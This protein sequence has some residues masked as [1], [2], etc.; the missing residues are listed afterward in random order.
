MN[1]VEHTA[2]RRVGEQSTFGRRFVARLVNAPLRLAIGLACV[3]LPMRL[4]VLDQ[5][6]RYGSK[7]ANYLWGVLPVV[8]GYLPVQ[9]CDILIRDGT[10]VDSTGD[11]SF[12]GDLGS[13]GGRIFAMGR[14]AAKVRLF[15]QGMLR[16][17][18]WADVTVFNPDTII[19]KATQAGMILYG[20]GETR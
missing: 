2:G 11:P 12:H 4:L 7:D 18:M 3:Y 9:D 8:A 17:G 19:D 20:A 16:S 15:D 10:I 5:A 14:N 13:K 1:S 6:R